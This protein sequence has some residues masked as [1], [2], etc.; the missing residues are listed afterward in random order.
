MLRDSGINDRD[1]KKQRKYEKN[2]RPD[3]RYFFI[4]CI[5][6]IFDLIQKKQKHGN[7]GQRQQNGNAAVRLG[8]CIQHSHPNA[9]EQQTQEGNYLRRVENTKAEEKK[10][11][12]AFSSKNS[13][14]EHGIDLKTIKKP[15]RNKKE[16]QC[17]DGQDAFLFRTFS[18]HS[19]TSF[20]KDLEEG[21][22][23]AQTGR[24]SNPGTELATKHF[25]S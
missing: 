23:A 5:L 7:I 17:E 15:T 19:C 2:T 22:P 12:S 18:N 24:Y 11:K 16:C 25:C 6:P 20:L 9:S 4:C 10:K 13:R 8:K 1:Q 3:R 14:V 21:S